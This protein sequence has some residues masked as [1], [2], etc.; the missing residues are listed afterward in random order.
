MLQ[1]FLRRWP[2]LTR[3]LRALAGAFCIEMLILANLVGY[4][5][6]LQ[7]AEYLLACGNEKLFLVSFAAWLCAKTQ[8][9]LMIRAGGKENSRGPEEH[10]GR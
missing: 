9:M 10:P 6:G 4:S 7:G 8:L 2:L 3:H 5:Y 1:A